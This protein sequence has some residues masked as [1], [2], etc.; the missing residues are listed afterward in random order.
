MHPSVNEIQTVLLCKGSLL[1][2]SNGFVGPSDKLE[3]EQ[4]T[5]T[6]SCGQERE[7]D[8]M[9]DWW[10]LDLNSIVGWAHRPGIQN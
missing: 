9:S 4:L 3:P 2:T 7:P 1:L 5:E 8:A 10:L 6:M